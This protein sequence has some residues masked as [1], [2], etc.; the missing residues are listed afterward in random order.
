[1]VLS[2]YYVPMKEAVGSMNRGAP[3]QQPPAAPPA[4]IPL[5]IDFYDIMVG[6]AE[7]VG[8]YFNVLKL[9]ETNRIQTEQSQKSPRQKS[10][11]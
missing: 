11:I 7:K 1:M 2:E 9:K 4:S 5:D 8:E 10:S 3:I 6:F